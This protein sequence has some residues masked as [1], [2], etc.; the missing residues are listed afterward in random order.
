MSQDSCPASSG[1]FTLI[2]IIVV[3]VI[4]GILAVAGIARMGD[5]TDSASKQRLHTLVAAAQSQLSLEYSRRCL[6][7]ESVNIA[8]QT[9]CDAVAISS[10]DIAASIVCVGN[11]DATVNITATMDGL[12]LNGTWSSPS[13]SGS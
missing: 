13:A 11:V 2:E 9:A 4:L 1:G 8:S 12:S 3:L 5:M 7:G 6:T 10:P